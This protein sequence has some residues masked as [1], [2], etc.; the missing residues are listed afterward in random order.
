VTVTAIDKQPSIISLDDFAPGTKRTIDLSAP[1]GFRWKLD[2][3]THS[4]LLNQAAGAWPADLEQSDFLQRL[5]TRETYPFLNELFDTQ[6][7]KADGNPAPPTLAEMSNAD[8]I[9]PVAL[10][11]PSGVTYL[12]LITR[13]KADEN[14]PLREGVTIDLAFAGKVEKVDDMTGQALPDAVDTTRIAGGVRLHNIQAARIP[15]AIGQRCKT[16]FKLP[17]YRITP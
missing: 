16:P 2:F 6:V 17:I 5:K 4:G 10:R 8:G 9:I 11:K 14:G 15:G 7:L 1:G 12:L 3:T 13:E